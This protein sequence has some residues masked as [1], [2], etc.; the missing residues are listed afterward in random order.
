MPCRRSAIGLMFARTTSAMTGVGL[1]NSRITRAM[2]AGFGL[3]S[4]ATTMPRTK[5]RSFS[6][7]GRSAGQSTAESRCVL[8]QRA[9]WTASR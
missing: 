7:A 6:A 5:C 9:C 1:A 2:P 4:K 3:P 8:K